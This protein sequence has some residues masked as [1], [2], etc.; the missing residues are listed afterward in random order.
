MEAGGLTRVLT[1]GRYG[2]IPPGS[3]PGWQQWGWEEWVDLRH[4]FQAEPAGVPRV[5]GKGEKREALC[6]IP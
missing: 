1:G 6:P 3:H 4:T 2:C 5:E